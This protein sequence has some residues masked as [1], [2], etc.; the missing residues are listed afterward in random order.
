MSSP[1]R[2]IEL[3]KK[4]DLPRAKKRFPAH[5]EKHTDADTDST[6]PDFLPPNKINQAGTCREAPHSIKCRR[7]H[8]G[9]EV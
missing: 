4:K 9:D 6:G 5:G 7:K 3:I 2:M 8:K 1:K